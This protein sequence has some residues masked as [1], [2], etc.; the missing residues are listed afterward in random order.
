MKNLIISTALGA[1]IVAATPALSSERE[2]YAGLPLHDY[3]VDPGPREVVV[4]EQQLGYDG[5]PATRSIGANVHSAEI[6]HHEGY[7]GLPLVGPVRND[8][9]AAQE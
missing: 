6:A 3:D 9:M 5:L 4:D 1:M 7:D 2:D 8:V